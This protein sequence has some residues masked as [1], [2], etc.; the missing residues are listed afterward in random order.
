MKPTL[1]GETTRTALRD[2][3]ALMTSYAKGLSLVTARATRVVLPRGHR[4][5]RKPVVRVH[6]SRAHAAVV[7][8]QALLRLMAAPAEAG[9]SRCHLSMPFEPPR[10]VIR[11]PHPARRQQITRRKV[12][13]HALAAPSSTLGQ[14]AQGTLAS[15]VAPFRAGL[16]VAAKTALHAR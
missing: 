3:A 6:G 7:A 4:V 14:V 1:G 12:G 10:T 2:A 15:S 16:L 9:I 5:Q 13:S 11:L 8:I